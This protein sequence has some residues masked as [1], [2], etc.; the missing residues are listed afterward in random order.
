MRLTKTAYYYSGNGELLGYDG[1]G[2]PVYG[3]PEKLPFK[4]EIEP[5][6]TELAKTQYGIFA[7]V[8]YRMFTK[9]NSILTLGTTII[10]RDEEFEIQKVWDYDRH[11]ELLINKVGDVA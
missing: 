4:M 8:N 1:F 7:D 3:E 6:S 2:R 11:Y 5:Y 10:Y 9:P